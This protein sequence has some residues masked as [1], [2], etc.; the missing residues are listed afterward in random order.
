MVVT[1]LAGAILGAIVGALGTY[2]LQGWRRKKQEKKEIKNLRNSLL[3]ELS[4]MDDLLPSDYDQR[5]DTL[6][7]GMSIPSNV[8]ESNSGRLSILSQTETDRVIRF[9]SGALKFQKM[10][11]ESMHLFQNNDAS[12]DD[13]VE[14][15]GGKDKIQQEWVRCVLILLENSDEYPDAIQFEG[16]RIEPDQDIGVREL[17]I[18][19]NHEGI[20]E[21]GMEA[22]PVVS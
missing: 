12:P 11:E 8:F 6:P 20:S 18:F 10:I 19:L 4:N 7:I 17:W 21:R 15:R 1:S 14:E 22:E 2:M 13:I 3:A 16:R 9:Y 5:G